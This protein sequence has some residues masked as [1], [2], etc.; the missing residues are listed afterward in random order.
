MKRIAIIFLTAL[1]CLLHA[2]LAIAGVAV[3][4][5]DKGLLYTGRVDFTDPRAPVISWPSTAVAANFVGTSLAVTL[6][7]EKGQNYFNVIL[8]G[9]DAAPLILQA[10]RGNKT[11]VLATGLKPGPHSFLITKRTEGA[12]GATVLRGFELSDGGQLLPPPP[13]PARRMEVFGDSITSGLGNEAPVNGR[14]DALRDK[15]SYMSYASIAARKLGAELH[16]TSQS[17]IGVMISWF[18]F[19]MPE[20]YGQ[21]SAVGKNDTRWEFPRW[22]P[23]V[24]VIN[25]MQND[26]WLIDDR[27]RLQPEPNEEQRIAAYETFVQRIRKAYP[28]A[29]I[30]C[31]LG[32]MDATRP[33]SKWP[34]YVKAAVERLRRGGDER[35]DSIF[36][37]YTGYGAH[38]RVVQQK[39]MAAKLAAHIQR[40][41]G[42]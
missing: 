2:S 14:D 11:Y 23:D 4:A 29:Y 32:S 38:P 41:M 37:E 19:T 18:P 34:G 33:G 13:R 6:D 24:V 36:F 27:H 8:D 12:E 25:L 9:D 21:M 31:A 20:F 10:D 15:N 5:D 42:W 28:K 1:S 7:D 30:V 17:G 16:M 26:R 35:I 22:T 39:D 40:A 3:P